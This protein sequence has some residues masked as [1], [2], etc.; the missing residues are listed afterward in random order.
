VDAGTLTAMINSVSESTLLTT[1]SGAVVADGAPRGCH[2]AAV[3]RLREAAQRG[4]RSFVSRPGG[5][6]KPKLPDAL[7]RSTGARTGPVGGWL[8]PEYRTSPPTGDVPT[9]QEASVPKALATAAL[10]VRPRTPVRL[11]MTAALLGVG[12]PRHGESGPPTYHISLSPDTTSCRVGWPV[13]HAPHRA[14]SAA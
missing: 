14:L 12:A 10:A 5:L 8:E 4:D 6:R 1:M 2:V 9:L 13:D 11:P 3:Q 7:P